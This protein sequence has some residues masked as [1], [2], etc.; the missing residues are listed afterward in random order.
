MSRPAGQGLITVA[1]HTS[2][3]DDPS[4]PCVMLPLSFILGESILPVLPLQ[5]TIKR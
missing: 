1:N 5:S 4:L 2:T 3:L